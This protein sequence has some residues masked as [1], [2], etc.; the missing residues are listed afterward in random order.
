MFLYLNNE[1]LERTS[2]QPLRRRLKLYRRSVDDVGVVGCEGIG[3]VYTRICNV[4]IFGG[5]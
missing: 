2:L 5:R 1:L 3:G 4:L